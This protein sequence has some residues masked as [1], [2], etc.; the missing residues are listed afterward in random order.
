MSPEYFALIE[1]IAGAII[2]VLLAYR[3]IQRK[4]IYHMLFMFSMIFFSL[5]ELGL[6]LYLLYGLIGDK[7]VSILGMYI[8]TLWG[9]G[10]LFLLQG[11]EL[12]PK[13]K[14]QKSW[15]KYYLFSTLI[16]YGAI[17]GATL[18]VGKQQWVIVSPWI[19][20]MIPG[21]FIA[22]S[23][24]ISSF[25]LG[26]KRNILITIAI[27][28]SIVGEQTGP[29]IWGSPANWVDTTAEILIGVG[30]ILAMEPSPRKVDEK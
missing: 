22:I 17:I 20:L 14:V 6:F 21:A 26:K 11:F 15:P 24:S 27:L 1:A 19:F 30:L 23:G 5:H 18:A 29:M 2:A 9:A 10:M 16:I 25:F 4:K 28:L 13:V 12:F 8:T 7:I 3:Y